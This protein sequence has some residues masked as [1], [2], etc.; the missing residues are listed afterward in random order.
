VRLGGINSKTVLTAS[1]MALPTLY[2]VGMVFGLYNAIV[3]LGRFFG[4]PVLN[5]DDWFLTHSWPFS[6]EYMLFTAFFVATVWLL[7]GRRGV[8]SFAVSTVFIGGV[9]LFYTI[10]T[11]YPNGTFTALQALVPVTT[12]GVEGV[13][14]MLGY[15]TETYSMG[16]AGLKLTVTGAGGNTYSAIVAWSCAGSHSL[17]LYSFMIMLFLRGTG[18]PRTRKIVYVAVGAAGTFLVN[19]L[20]IVVIYIVGIHSGHSPAQLFHEFYGEFFFIGWMFT[21]LTVIFLLET[22]VF[23]ESKKTGNMNELKTT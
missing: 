8:G 5:G 15:H 13:L 2:A 6:F 10:D 23:N 3:E 4:V 19:I 22:R 9:A 16:S 14:N 11:F 1:V 20:R 7:Y 17:F 18:I 21:Y 12:S